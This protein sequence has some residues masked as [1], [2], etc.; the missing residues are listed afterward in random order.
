MARGLAGQLLRALYAHHAHASLQHT[1]H[2]I[3]VR[4]CAWGGGWD[5][6]LHVLVVKVVLKVYASTRSGRG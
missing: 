3:N 2:K 6:S 4:A 1:S 5:R